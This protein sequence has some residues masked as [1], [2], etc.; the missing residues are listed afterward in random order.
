MVWGSA[1][2]DYGWCNV[3]C[4]LCVF[5]CIVIKVCFIFHCS[6]IPCAS[7]GSMNSC[8]CQAEALIHQGELNLNL[9]QK[10]KEKNTSDIVFLLFIS[11][12]FLSYIMTQTWHVQQWF[13]LYKILCCTTVLW[14]LN[15]FK[16]SSWVS[17]GDFRKA[18]IADRLS[19]NLLW[20]ARGQ[21][22]YIKHISIW[23]MLLYSIHTVC[24][25]VITLGLFGMD[26][27]SIFTSFSISISRVNVILF[28]MSVKSLLCTHWGAFIFPN[29]CV[30]SV[31]SIL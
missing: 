3:K 22:I 2:K 1:L 6:K 7:A 15:A 5:I 23:Q 20:R 25:T 10:L 19:I 31:R 17:W 27:I 24:Y 18:V 11:S 8:P 29:G 14:K 12:D 4:V 26:Y 28:M 9:C 30:G 21:K 13:S 16:T